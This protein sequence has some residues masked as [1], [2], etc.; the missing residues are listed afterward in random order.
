MVTF[1][2][3]RY[4]N[5]I[6]VKAFIH[7]NFTNILCNWYKCNDKL[8]FV[9]GNS[10]TA[11][12]PLMKLYKE[13]QNWYLCVKIMQEELQY[14]SYIFSFSMKC[15]AWCLLWNCW[16]YN[17]FSNRSCNILYVNLDLWTMSFLCFYCTQ[18]WVGA[19][20]WSTYVCV[21]GRD[22]I[23]F[24][25]DVNLIPWCPQQKYDQNLLLS[26]LKSWNIRKDSRW[27]GFLVVIIHGNT[28]LMTDKSCKISLYMSS[29]TSILRENKIL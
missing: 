18:T 1:L 20:N 22:N 21:M 19:E 25:R 6:L 5:G 15:T 4:P 16:I 28:P 11:F 14:I 3:Q 17:H 8:K 7:Y 10:P 12:Q 2:Q 26:C 29:N 24:K 13:I 9:K 23:L 27:R